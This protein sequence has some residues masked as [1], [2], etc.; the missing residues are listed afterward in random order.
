LVSSIKGIVFGIVLF[1]VAFPVLWWNE[2]RAVKTARMLEEVGGNVKSVSADKV[3]KSLEGKLVHVSGKATTSETLK[4]PQFGVSA[5]AVKLARKVE[6][7][8]WQEKSESK[9][10][11]KLGGGTETVTT[12]NY[13]K[14]WSDRL[15]PS[16]H[17]K[18]PEGHQNPAEMPF[19]AK[20]WTA[21]E[22]ML[23][24]Y[25]LS[26]SLVAQISNFT[27]VE[28][29]Q[30]VFDSLPETLKKDLKLQG[31]GLY[32]GSNPAAPQV[33]DARISFAAALPTEVSLIAKQQG[34]SFVPYVASNGRTFEVL[35]AGLK[36]AEQMVESAKSSNATMTWILRLVGLVMMTVGLA[37]VF[38]PL[39]VVA[40]VIPLLGSI[41]RMGTGLIAFLISL[42]LSLITIAVA[43]IA[44][45]PVLAVCLLVVA[46][47]VVGGIVFLR[48]RREPAGE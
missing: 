47:L 6:M 12:Y 29:A 21:A 15:V 22:V 45:R 13:S 32:R 11:N 9:T 26:A 31:G 25:K 46:G 40:D 17:F 28:V 33:G 2:G 19:Q 48:S 1:L 23:G 7:H 24:A 4:D 3:D 43:W 41:V 38:A 39:A 8:Q 30:S 16:D 35:E 37:C 44:Y 20:T 10:Q 14:A 42:P 18:K 5:K 34:N 27:P 36:S